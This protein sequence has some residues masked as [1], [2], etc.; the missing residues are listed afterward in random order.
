MCGAVE[1]SSGLCYFYQM[2]KRIVYSGIAVLLV[3]SGCQMNEQV[4][5]SVQ[6]NSQEYL[7]QAVTWYQHSAEMKAAY[8]QAFNW[9]GRILK[10]EAK[11]ES[12]LPLAVVLDI[13]ETVLDNSPQTARQ[14]LDGEAFSNEMWDEWCSLAKA[15]PLPGALEFTLLARAL[16]VEVFYI[17]NRGIHLLDVSLENLKSAG[18]PNADS[19]HVLLKT[20]SSVKDE[21]RAK[22]RETHDVVLLIG[23]NLGDF[24]GIF[25]ERQGDFA[26]ENV[27]KNRDMFGF[28]FII[29][30]NP[31]YGGWEK[32][33][34]EASPALTKQNKME[35]LRAYQR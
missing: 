7:L 1:I 24:S 3:I 8:I 23:D 31:L 26:S 10:S 11:L 20:G 27:M 29:L 15:E 28:E 2:K 22:V 14:I 25:D 6:A 16:G 18:F 13:D 30:P 32:P 34:R 33:F 17:S 5:Q 35:S 9:A 12:A 21:R 19:Q 4:S